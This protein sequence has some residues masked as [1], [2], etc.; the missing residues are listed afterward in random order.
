LKLKEDYKT[1]GVL[2]ITHLSENCVALFRFFYTAVTEF[3]FGPV[4]RRMTEI[5]PSVVIIHDII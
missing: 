1:F 4:D 5:E 3:V 2:V